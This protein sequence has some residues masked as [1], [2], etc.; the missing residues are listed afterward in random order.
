MTQTVLDEVL[1]PRDTPVPPILPAAPQPSCASIAPPARAAA[2]AR[3]LRSRA[4]AAGLAALAALTLACF[5]SLPWS[6]RYYDQQILSFHHQPPRLSAAVDWFGRDH[7][8]RSLLARTLLGG[9]VSLGVGLLAAAVSVVIG[10][11]CG[12]IAG[13]FGGRIDALLM[14]TVDVLLSLPYVLVVMLLTMSLGARL[15]PLFG[16]RWTSFLVVAVALGSVSWLTMARVI[17]GQVLALRESP[18]VEA[19]RALGI[20]AP[21]LVLRHVLPNLVGP[22]IV[23]A[24]L[25]VPQAILQESFLS[26]LGLGVQEPLPSWG[27]LAGASVDAMNTIRFDWWLVLFPCAALSLTLLSLNFVGDGLRDALDPRRTRGRAE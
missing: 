4:S 25:T 8:G 9:C 18:F 26:F 11:A 23:Y 6:A 7:L 21:R 5:A 20:P 14:R 13:F 17:R 3:L 10:V 24:T 12:L 2:T 22:I 27:S 19:A 15:A 16:Q 1:P